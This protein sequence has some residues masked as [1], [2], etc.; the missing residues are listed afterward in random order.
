MKNIFFI[1]LI[2]TAIFL[3]KIIAQN[4]W[5]PVEGNIKTR[6]A[7][8]VDPN[9]PHPEYPRPN[10]IRED[11]INL[12]GLWNYELTGLNENPNT[13]NQQILVPFPIESSLSGVKK[14]VNDSTLL[15]YKRNFSIPSYWNGK[16]IL[17]HFEAVDWQTKVWINDKFAGEHKGGYDPFSFDITEYLNDQGEQTLMISVWDPTDIG[18]QPCGKQVQNPGGIFYT[19]TTGIWQTVWLEPVKEIYIK[20]YFATPDIDNQIIKL[21]VNANSKSLNTQLIISVKENKKIIQTYSGS[22]QDSL[23]FKIDQPIL[24]SPENPFLYDLEISLLN[25]NQIIDQIFGYFGMRKISLE[26][27]SLGRPKMFLNNKFVFQNG[28]LDQGFWPDGIYTAPTDEALKSDIEITKELGFNMLRKHV[29][30]ESRRFYYWCD[31][32]GILVWQDMPS[33]DKKISPEESDLIRS[34]ESANQY[35]FEL[36]KLISTRFNNPSVIMWVPFN[37][38]WGQFDTERITKKIKSLDP[39]RL[40]NNTSGWSDRNVGDIYDIH[41]YPA[42][43]MPEA[44]NDRAIV[45][46]EFGG[47][48]LR[49]ADHTWTNE[50]WGYVS[51][52][53]PD[54]LLFNYEKFYSDIWNYAKDSALSAVVYTQTTDVETEVNG[55]LSYDREIIKLNK[56]ALKNIN[57]GNFINSPMIKPNGGLFNIGDKVEILHDDDNSIYYTLDGSEPN[58]NSYKYI[59]PIELNSDVTIKTKAILNEKESRTVKAD[60]KLTKLKRPKYFTS[61]SN[62]YRANGDFALIDGKLGTELYSDGNWQGFEGNDVEIIFEINWIKKINYVSINFL[63][64]LDKWIFLPQFVNLQISEDGINFTTINKLEI[65]QPTNYRNPFIKNISFKTN[66]RKFN[67]IKLVAKNIKTIPEW[68]KGKNHD[69]WIFIDEISFN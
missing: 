21:K 41:S 45:I 25:N 17:L 55:L 67:F 63:E 48:G 19:S 36:E 50:N 5:K 59:H 43:R 20:E 34:D 8:D 52:T 2:F 30:V 1:L 15:W 31:K 64:D 44:Q 16:N 46:G 11:W 12:N 7:K 40:V 18:T 53:D 13:F 56:T 54:E 39:S 47:M 22:Y 33:G 51:F 24:W 42:P 65:D 27:D 29:K 58:L 4:S 37:E 68:H 38:G 3:N 62:K 61:F 26:K 6:W 66:G 10:L 69:A 14:S 9:N 28:P 32:L 57:T 49:I 35:E 23:E 60:F